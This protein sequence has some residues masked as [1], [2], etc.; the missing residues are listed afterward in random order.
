MTTF[1]PPTKISDFL[2]G[3]TLGSGTFVKVKSG[4]H[5]PSGQQVAIK[6]L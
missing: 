4:L 2:L 1:K 5:M 3:K 6:I